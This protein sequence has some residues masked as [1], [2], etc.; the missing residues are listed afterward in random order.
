MS[1]QMIHMEIAYRLLNKLPQI[2]NSAEF[3]LGSVAPDS[4]HMSPSYDVSKKVVSHMFEG[5][6]PWS[7]TQDYKRWKSNIK[8]VFESVY[9]KS[10]IEERRDFVL[11]LC[12]HCL[13]DYWNDVKIWKR[14]QGEYLPSME[15][16]VFRNAYYPEA[17]GIDQWLYQNSKNTNII[18]EMLMKA[19]AFD[20]KEL[21]AKDNIEKQRSHL[22]NVQYNVEMID[23]SSYQFLSAEDIYEFID[24]VVDDIEKTI[25]SWLRELE[26]T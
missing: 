10:D 24:F 14:L 18:R 11:G 22:L 19:K 4:V 6:G 13:T 12:V 15:F 20:V 16:E 5:C 8:N 23:I 21:V 3:I 25:K 9:I 26:D 7:D 17:Q 1:F 2:N